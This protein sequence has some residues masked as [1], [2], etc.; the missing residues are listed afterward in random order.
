MQAPV[1]GK[2][3]LQAAVSQ[4]PAGLSLTH[5][6]DSED[7]E[8]SVVDPRDQ[9]VQQSSKADAAD[10][11]PGASSGSSDRTLPDSA[12]P[13][14]EASQQQAIVA[15][16]TAEVEPEQS[17]SHNA[18]EAAG[19]CGAAHDTPGTNRQ[20]AT[21]AALEIL[22]SINPKERVNLN[23][24]DAEAARCNDC[25]QTVMGITGRGFGRQDL[26]DNIY[27]MGCCKEGMQ[28]VHNLNEL[29]LQSFIKLLRNV[30]ILGFCGSQEEAFR[31]LSRTS[32]CITQ[33]SSGLSCVEPEDVLQCI[34]GELKRQ[35]TL[36]QK[37]EGAG[38]WDPSGVKPDSPDIVRDTATAIR[39]RG[40]YL[41]AQ[42]RSG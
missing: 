5:V 28:S 20:D 3:Q 13:R 14:L 21:Q 32:P 19:E 25:G 4:Q 9:D 37:K 7:Q 42:L 33:R 35:A 10:A 29:E 22:I 16:G 26:A 36:G 11:T 12:H 30:P 8:G 17:R 1:R 31:E 23:N 18:A 39:K 40:R 41:Q 24:T 34:Q 38:D 2:S 27:C 6:P 15:S